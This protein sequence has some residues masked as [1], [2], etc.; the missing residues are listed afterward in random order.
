MGFNKVLVDTAKYLKKIGFY[1]LK[2]Y[3]N[4][5]SMNTVTG[6]QIIAERT[7]F[8][9][10]SFQYNLQTYDILTA[11]TGTGTLS[12]ANAKAQLLCGTGIGRAEIESKDPI[13]YV[14]GHEV[15]CEGTCIFSTPEVGKKQKFGIG[16]DVDG[17]A[18]VGYDGLTFGVWLRTIDD[19]ELHI[20]QSQFTGEAGALDPTK[21]NIFKITYG[22]Y[23]I[24]PINFSIFRPDLKE[25]VEIYS[26]NKVNQALNPHMKNPSLPFKAIIDRVSGSGV[27]I[28]MQ[29]SS[30]RGGIAGKVG[31]GVLAD[32]KFVLKT[33]KSVSG[34]NVPIM[35]I[36]NNAT[37]QGVTNHVRVR[38]GT[39][40]VSTDGN[41]AVEFDVYKGGTLTGGVWTAY[42]SVN[43]VCDYNNT[44]TSFTPATPLPSGG[45]VLG[46]IDR[47]RINL[48]DG[49]VVIP[50]YAGEEIHIVATTPTANDVIL[51]F[52]HIEEF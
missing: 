41:K 40:T 22:W 6:E 3:A 52:R 30:W 9:N 28:P 7:D 29:T 23:G 31:E 14:T 39:F 20:P 24:L 37:F 45:T 36:R 35:S 12:H 25:W 27:D 43:S 16:D 48:I 38:I 2:D 46:K 26:Y 21:F 5:Q 17:F 33:S 42:D 49:D 50:L 11:T 19:G 18:G 4:K 15:S 13:R 34:T 47:D 51:Y 10:V 44:A 8:V 1:Q 32:R